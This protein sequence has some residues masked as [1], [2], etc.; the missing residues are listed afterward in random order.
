M[1]MNRHNLGFKTTL[2]VRSILLVVPRET[3]AGQ[4]KFLENSVIPFGQKWRAKFS[5]S[6]V[7]NAIASATG[8]IKVWLAKGTYGAGDN[9]NLLSFGGIN[10]LGYIFEFVWTDS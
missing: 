4:L 10:F 2:S 8:G 5:D 9:D 7:V 6:A 1:E 3:K